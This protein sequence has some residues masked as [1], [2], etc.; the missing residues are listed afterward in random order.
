[1]SGAHLTVLV[2]VLTFLLLT[3][4]YLRLEMLMSHFGPQYDDLL[5]AFDS[6][7]SDVAKRIDGLL[8]AIESQHANG[9]PMTDAQFEAF[10]GIA[11]HLKALGS[12]VQAPTPPLPPLAEVDGTPVVAL[13]SKPVL[14][15]ER[16]I[17][18]NARQFDSRAAD[19]APE[20]TPSK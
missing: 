4:T 16:L 19:T 17:V 9:D 10:K 13:V 20:S 14:V 15:D 18:S 2:T 1:M 5:K 7:T 11:D 8:A 6:A 3:L 12:D